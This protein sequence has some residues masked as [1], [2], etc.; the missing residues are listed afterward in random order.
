ML[1][2]KEKGD[3]NGSIEH[4][5]LAIDLKRDMSLAW[6]KLG[7][8]LTDIHQQDEAI[9]AYEVHNP[10]GTICRHLLV[11]SRVVQGI[12]SFVVV[13][14]RT[15]MLVD[16]DI[17]QGE[18]N[19]KHKPL[20]TIHSLCSHYRQV[21]KEA[22]LS[23]LSVSNYRTTICDFS[24]LT[25]IPQM[26][27]KIPTAPRVYAATAFCNHGHLVQTRAGVDYALLKR[28]LSLFRRWGCRVNSL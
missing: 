20:N 4:Y 1:P 7:G 24:R 5:R 10:P 26:V 14:R 27:T 9:A 25:L 17:S 28:G 21:R 6:L 3:I 15:G 23:I 12:R 11:N 22:I 16:W 19:E 8:A 13:I 18:G 2:L